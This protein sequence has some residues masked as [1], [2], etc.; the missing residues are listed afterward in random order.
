VSH[1]NG[2]VLPGHCRSIGRLMCLP[3]VRT[4]LAT[5]VLAL[6]I[7]RG[8]VRLANG[9]RLFWPAS[10]KHPPRNGPKPTC[11]LSSALQLTAI[12]IRLGMPSG[13][14]EFNHSSHSEWAAIVQPA[15][16]RVAT[17]NAQESPRCAPTRVPG[18]QDRSRSRLTTARFL[19]I[20]Q[21]ASYDTTA[22]PPCGW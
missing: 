10:Q 13:E 20:N 1:G 14:R 3:R 4:A 19:A 15:R 8:S 18:R 17:M 2:V 12:R 5:S 21:R 6:L 9:K 22:P 7:R 11:A 16:L